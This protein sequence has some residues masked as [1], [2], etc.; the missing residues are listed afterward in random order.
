M[1]A[2]AYAGRVGESDALDIWRLLRS[3]SN[4][5][6]TAADWPIRSAARD[7]AVILQDHFATPESGGPRR[8]TPNRTN[9]ARIRALIARVV[10]NPT[11][12]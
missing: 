3:A 6:H 10:P 12:I 9:Q 4:A 7:A 8:A 2:H 11:R 1:K 5:G